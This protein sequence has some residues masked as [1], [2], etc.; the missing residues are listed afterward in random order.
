[1]KRKSM[2][3][4]ACGNEM[5]AIEYCPDCMNAIEDVLM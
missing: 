5:N 2:H 1:M 3:C 4:R